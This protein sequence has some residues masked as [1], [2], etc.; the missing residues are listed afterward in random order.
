M[1]SAAT[2]LH[3]DVLRV[4]QAWFLVLG[5][6]NALYAVPIG[7]QNDALRCGD[8]R[9]SADDIPG[10]TL[11]K[12][13]LVRTRELQEV[14]S[15][16]CVEFRASDDLMRRVRVGL[17]REIALERDTHLSKQP[18]RESCVRL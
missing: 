5:F 18:I 10:M 7:G 17:D 14:P 12:A 15:G 6:G 8:V 11:R 9:L 13:M 16:G 1:Q 2:V 4:D 3:G